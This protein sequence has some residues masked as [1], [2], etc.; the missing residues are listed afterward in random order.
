LIICFTGI[1]GF[2][3][4]DWRTSSGAFLKLRVIILNICKRWEGAAP[5]DSQKAVV[6]F[7]C[8]DTDRFE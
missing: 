6:A 7:I 4:G 8:A 5:G 1:E 2:F 3:I